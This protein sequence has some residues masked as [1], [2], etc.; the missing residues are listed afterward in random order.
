VAG[1]TQV[2]EVAAVGAP[3]K[4]LGERICVFVVLKPGA[5]LSIDEIAAGFAVLGVARQKTPEL[6][7]IVDALPRNATGKVVKADLRAALAGAAA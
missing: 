7:R 3:D 4:R 2:A 6:L 5:T 1:M